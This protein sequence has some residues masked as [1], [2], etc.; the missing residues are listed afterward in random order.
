MALSRSCP[1]PLN[2]A[3]HRTKPGLAL[4][5]LAALPAPALAHVRWF[6]DADAAAMAD[7]PTY[8]ITDPPVL[9]WIV[10]GLVL[11]VIAICLDGRLPKVPVVNSKIRH[12]AME[13]LR[14]FTGMSL[15][16]TAYG[17]ALIAPHLLAYGAFGYALLFLQAFI[18]IM[19]ISNHF[20][21]HAAILLVVLLLGT[22]V[23]Y[24]FVQAFEYVNLVGIALFLFFN[25][26]PN[27]RLRETLKPYSVD[28]LRIF[29][30]IAL[31]TLGI[32][33]KL[34]GAMLGQSFIAE[35]RW[36]FMPMLGF[37]WYSDQLFVLSA[38][39]MEVVFGIIMILGVITRL[40]TFVIAAFMLTSNIVFLLTGQNENALM[41]LVGHMPIIATA[42]IL[43]L[44]GYG[45]RLKLPNPTLGPPN[46]APMT[47]AE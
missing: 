26:V 28:M 8:A 41:E 35:F 38:G 37:E 1:Q 46:S 22:L 33:E 15:L 13:L 12:D 3:G 39:A 2:R 18:G 14:V 5:A 4:L 31:V 43:L 6:T 23:Q 21:H 47:P 30:G 20:V 36:N 32:T 9:T 25:H 42:I 34:S 29:T 24:G 11:V 17:G 45:Q 27:M 19:L 40:N 7:F 16:L 10:I 44:L